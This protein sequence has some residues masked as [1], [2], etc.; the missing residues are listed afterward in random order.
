MN[1][2]I[3]K[4]FI[5]SV[6]FSFILIPNTS[7]LTTENRLVLNNG[8][9]VTFSELKTT[10]CNSEVGTV[11]FPK[12]LSVDGK[13]IELYCTF[14]DRELAVEELYDMYPEAFK[15]LYDN[16]DLPSVITPDNWKVFDEAI[17]SSYDDVELSHEM[18][19]DLLAISAFFDIYENNEENEEI[20]ELVNQYNDLFKYSK[21]SDSSLFIKNQINQLIPDYSYK[22]NTSSTL[23]TYA[24]SKYNKPRAID[25]AVTYA[26]TPNKLEFGYLGDKDCTNFVSQIIDYAGYPQNYTG[27]QKTGWWHRSNVNAHT[28]S[29]SWTAADAFAE[30]M[31]VSYKTTDLT[32]WSKKAQAGDVIGYDK[33]NDGNFEHLGFVTKANGTEKKYT[34]DGKSILYYDLK[35]AQH[36]K[37]Y[38]QWTSGGASGW[39][40][41]VELGYGYG[42]LV[43]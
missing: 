38:H 3:I 6:L 4:L 42:I 1:G 22:F 18:N 28:Y 32:A 34:Y 41:L 15:Y 37:N 29:L 21:K 14:E 39:V 5:S 2:K 7:A 20:K 12:P 33:K 19:I 13:N 10:L 40:K 23:S 16:Y 26:T 43:K 17:T 25:Y 35:I 24:S 9:S 30:Y 31:G 11:I 8:N 27:N 36:S